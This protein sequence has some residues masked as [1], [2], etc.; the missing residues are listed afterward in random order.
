MREA[1]TLRRRA[2]TLVSYLLRVRQ[3]RKGVVV[4]GRVNNDLMQ[5][6]HEPNKAVSAPRW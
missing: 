5:A 2:M 3:V 1:T 6:K 4:H